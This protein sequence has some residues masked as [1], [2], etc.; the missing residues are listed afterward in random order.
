MT[1]PNTPGSS[2][3]ILVPSM[4]NWRLLNP[5][6]ICC[7][8]LARQFDEPMVDSSM[9]PTYL[10]SRLIRKHCTVAL[11]GDGGDELFGGYGHYNRLL[12]MQRRLGWIP[13]HL[14]CGIARAAETLLPVG[15]K[16]R[17]WLQG[18]EVDWQGGLPLIA[19]YFDRSARRS[20]MAGQ[21][22]WVLAAESIRKQRIPRTADLLQRATRMD[23][24]NYLAEDILVKQTKGQ[25]P[26][27]L[28]AANRMFHEDTNPSNPAILSLLLTSQLRI[29]ILFRLPWFFMRNMNIF[30]R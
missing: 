21:G 2:P 5:P 13:H 20:L 29:R 12:W 7:R 15:F 28:H 11:G 19:V 10:V 27:N 23:F 17:N 26:K 16:G 25:Y 3:G 9:I 18:L 1:K 30:G 14:R 22:S 6:W 4:S 24:E 8:V